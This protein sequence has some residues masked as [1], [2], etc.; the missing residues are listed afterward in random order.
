VLVLATRLLD[1]FVQDRLMSSACKACCNRDT[2]RW[3][4][5]ECEK[6]YGR[7][8]LLAGHIL[9]CDLTVSD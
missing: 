8:P 5:V 6:D 1:P 7:K 9:S 2:P 4:A 3:C